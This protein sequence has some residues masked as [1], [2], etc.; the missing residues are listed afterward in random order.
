MNRDIKVL[1]KSKVTG[2]IPVRYISNKNSIKICTVN[3]R[4]RVNK[5]ATENDAPKI[6]DYIITRDASGCYLPSIDNPTDFSLS[7][8]VVVDYGITVI[9]YVGIDPVV[10]RLQYYVNGADTTMPNTMSGNCVYGHLCTD[11]TLS[12]VMAS[13][14]NPDVIRL[15][16]GNAIG[17][18]GARTFDTNV[19]VLFEVYNP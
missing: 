2:N 9:T 17:L 10:C 8:T 12:T 11:D 19:G 3:S 18:Y 13:G 16:A 15:N 5:L 14:L 6:N 1:Y 7:F 4:N